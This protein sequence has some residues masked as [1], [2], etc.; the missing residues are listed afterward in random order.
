MFFTSTRA[1][2]NVT[3][4]QAIAPE[5]SVVLESTA[6]AD[7]PNVPENS[8]V[9]TLGQGGAISLRDRSTIYDR[10]FV[11]YV[12]ELAEKKQISA[13]LKKYV[14]GGND[15]GHIHKS[16]SGVKALAISAPS[17][18]IHSPACVVSKNDYLSMG[19]LLYAIVTEF[20]S[21]EIEK[22]A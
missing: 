22:N 3:A 2:K 17:R 5:Y 21:K 12:M 8:R 7:L 6:V 11:S 16:G 19:E 4:A 10:G 9:A 1:N 14:S 13:Q 15:A 18:Y 20:D